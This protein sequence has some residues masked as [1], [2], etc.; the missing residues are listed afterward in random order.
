MNSIVKKKKTKNQK[1]EGKKANSQEECS[2][3]FDG[4]LYIFQLSERDSVP[5]TQ[6]RFYHTLTWPWLVNL[7]EVGMGL[8]TCSAARARGKVFKARVPTFGGR[9]RA[10]MWKPTYLQVG[11]AV[12]KH[13][14]V[15]LESRSV[16]NARHATKRRHDAKRGQSL[17]TA[18]QS[19]DERSHERMKPEEEEAIQATYLEL[20]VIFVGKFEL[21]VIGGV[22]RRR[23][24]TESV[25]NHI[26]F[27]VRKHLRDW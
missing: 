23:T 15:E 25:E 7:A 2:D 4:M 19:K 14:R 26:A 6:T 9:K 12:K 27:S 13:H 17:C 24:N 21:V 20:L 8:R 18:P 16:H 3:R 11:L 10:L 1:K 22:H 5:A